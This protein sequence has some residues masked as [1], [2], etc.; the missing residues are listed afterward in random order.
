MVDVQP[1][2]RM[3]WWREARFGLLVHFGLYT[4]PDG[5]AKMGFLLSNH[6]NKIPAEEYLAVAREFHPKHFDA[7]VLAGL[8]AA[9]GMKY[10]VFTTKHHDGFAMFA[11]ADGFNIVD[12]TPFHRDPVKELAEACAK[13]GLKL[14]LYYSQDLD[15]TAGGGNEYSLSY[16][17]PSESNV[18][19]LEHKLKPQLRE[20]LTNYGPIGLIW[21][22]TPGF[23]ITCEQ[24]HDIRRF[25]LSLQPDC[26][27]NGRL[28]WDTADYGSLGD[29]QIPAGPAEGDWEVPATMNDSW[30]YRE[31]D[32]NWKPFSYQLKLLV[33]CASKGVNYLLNVG[34]KPDGTLPAPSVNALVDFADWMKW[35]GES[36]HGTRGNPFCT[37]FHWGTA[38]C[39]DRAIYLHVLDWP[40]GLLVVSGLVNEVTA[41]EMLGPKPAKLPFTQTTDT[42]S[43][44][45][46]L[47]IP[48]PETSN[49]AIDQVL[50]LNLTRKPEVDPLVCE[51]RKGEVD[52]ALHCSSQRGFAAGDVDI[53]GYIKNWDASDRRLEWSFR[54][55]GPGTF[56]VFVQSFLDRGLGY[57]N[58][59]DH[60]AVELGKPPRFGNH[61]LQVTVGDC[62]LTGVAGAKDL[63]LDPAVNR[64]HKGQSDFGTIQIDAAG[65][66]S[67]GLDLIERDGRSTLGPTICGV[68]LVRI[69]QATQ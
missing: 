37:D 25:V 21:F 59:N 19:Y 47:A 44:I 2:D 26:L 53:A 11:S 15:F 9:A 50:R 60:G 17:L 65:E 49:N 56:R 64:W 57:G 58:T 20:L 3:A 42:A 16:L 40:S 52:L 33:R 38:S 48:L 66:V 41:V 68:R 35:N 46:D 31:V 55:R 4:L 12:R 27:I 39:R 23:K 51:D 7:D 6:S 63:I 13:H 62:Q 43:G 34:P 1:N 22:D 10:L 24:A 8:A 69:L 5:S 29:N 32:N 28:G 54:V 67:L 18:E 36:I 45:R 14:C 61:T 30:S